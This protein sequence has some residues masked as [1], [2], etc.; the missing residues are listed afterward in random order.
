[1]KKGFLAEKIGDFG[2]ILKL[3]KALILSF[4]L[5]LISIEHIEQEIFM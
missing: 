2:R 4:Y 1:M 5:L 3:H